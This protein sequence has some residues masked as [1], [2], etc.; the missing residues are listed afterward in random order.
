MIVPSLFYFNARNER[1]WRWPPT[2]R[3]PI[4]IRAN[5]SDAFTRGRIRLRRGSSRLTRNFI[6]ARKVLI[7]WHLGL[8]ESGFESVEDGPTNILCDQWRNRFRRATDRVT[9]FSA[10]RLKRKRRSC[11]IISDT[12]PIPVW[13]FATSLKHRAGVGKRMEKEEFGDSSLIFR[14]SSCKC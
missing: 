1:A 2:T 6:G 14:C 5:I 4:C 3:N 10:S 12:S 8:P 11:R 9:T 7:D 13:R